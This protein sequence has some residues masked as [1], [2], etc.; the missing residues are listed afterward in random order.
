MKKK[1]S[2]LLREYFE[3]QIVDPKNNLWALDKT[4]PVQASPCQWEIHKNPERF[5]KTYKF[6]SRKRLKD[7]IFEVL[8]FEDDLNHHGDI[9]IRSDEVSVS[10]YTH[11]IN[12]ITE[13]DQEYTKNLDLIYRDVLDFEY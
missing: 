12:K 7:F 3:E 2:N 6:D 1:V 8:S 4:R 5:S 11:E 13:L 9:S 10:V